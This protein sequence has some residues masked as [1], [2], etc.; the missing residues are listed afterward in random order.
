MKVVIDFMGEGSFRVAVEPT[1]PDR[2]QL[3][4]T[5]AIH[6]RQ[7]AQLWARKW[8]CPIEDRTREDW[9]HDGA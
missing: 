7:Q 9:Q 1:A 3:Y 2:G 5:T 8:D 6:A 4:F